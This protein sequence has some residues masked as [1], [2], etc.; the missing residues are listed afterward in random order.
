MRH[1]SSH[2]VFR[3]WYI[4]YACHAVSAEELFNS[5]RGIKIGVASRFVFICWEGLPIPLKAEF[6]CID[7][8]R[9]TEEITP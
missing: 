9:D 4:L 2:V 8:C 5:V 7:F 6:P 1:W 3:K